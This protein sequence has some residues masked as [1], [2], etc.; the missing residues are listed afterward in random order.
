MGNYV[1]NIFTKLQ[2]ADRAQAII[3]AGK[4]AWDRTQKRTKEAEGCGEWRLGAAVVVP[5]PQVL[6]ESHGVVYAQDNPPYLANALR[7][8]RWRNLHTM[9]ATAPTQVMPTLTSVAVQ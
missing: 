3:R 9:L 6:G 5:L 4:R 8:Y 7:Y 1:S 2:V